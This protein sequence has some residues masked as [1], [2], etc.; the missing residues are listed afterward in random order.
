M[1]QIEKLNFDWR[2][3]IE[4]NWRSSL[5]R[6]TDTFL[7]ETFGESILELNDKLLELRDQASAI[8]GLILDIGKPYFGKTDTD[9]VFMQQF[10]K[11]WHVND[12]I[13]LED[14]I[15]FIERLQ[16]KL[17]K[18]DRK[19]GLTILSDTDIEMAR[20]VSIA[21]LADFYVQKLKRRGKNYLGCCPFHA[22]NSPSLVLYTESNR[23]Y[24]F[25]CHAH[26]DVIAFA[27]QIL[28]SDFKTAIHYLINF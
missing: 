25:G 18:P 5:P 19:G 13:T 2:G 26:G 11:Y 6:F 23:F 3:D 10:I 4:R 12:L 28:S 8:M 9:S 7:M 24:C 21:D 27:Q 17:R 1:I 14:N 22:D 15:R 20:R 16:K